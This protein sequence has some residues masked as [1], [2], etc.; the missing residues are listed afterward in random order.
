MINVGLAGSGLLRRNGRS[1]LGARG[2]GDVANAL[3]EKDGSYG[4]VA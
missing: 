2:Q 4:G 1:G 3:R